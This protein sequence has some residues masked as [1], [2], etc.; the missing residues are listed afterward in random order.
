MARRLAL[1]SQGLDGRW[2]LP[3]GKEGVAQAIERL[4]Y[5]QIDTISVVERAHH[6]T[7]WVRCPD[8]EKRMVHEL[9]AEDRRIFEWWASAMSYVPMADYRYYA[10]RMGGTRSWHRKW[11]AENQ[12]LVARVLDRIRDEGPL[13]SS[14]F[15]PPTD[16]Q[17]GDWW[18]WKPSKI[19]LECLFD[20]G[21]LMVT[22]RRNFQ[23]I[24]DL[25]ERVLP[26]GLDLS[27][28]EPDELARFEARRVLGCLG[29]AEVDHVQWARWGRKPI[30]AP[31]IQDLID[32]GEVTAFQ[33]EGQGE[34]RFC[35]LTEPLH[36]VLNQ[37]VDGATPVVHILSPFDSLII[38]RGWLRTHFGFRY[39]LE[40]YTPKAKR[41]YGYF[42]L[43]ILWGEQ[44]VGR[45]DA[46][47]D[48][49]PRTFILRQLTFE[50]SFQG[51]DGV[52]PPFVDTLRAFATFNGCE[53]FQIERT[54]PQSVKAR[55]EE[56]L[57]S[58]D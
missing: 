43:P 3:A 2:D 33:I 58:G 1:Y 29:F 35:A 6:H 38:R 21:E 8:Y 23:R 55:L 22:E 37:A 46:K 28:P 39:K 15:K 12:E 7:L 14:D 42:A 30:Q 44:L 25:R 47:A 20:M 40:A 41:R 13:G 4:G 34:K 9:Q 48:R 24:Y 57:T 11:Y 10:V 51:F 18:S 52:L 16:F 54:A 36:T 49:K 5:V 56:A 50:P 53:R 26:S 17:R 19:A 31:I 45:L 27:T 32:E